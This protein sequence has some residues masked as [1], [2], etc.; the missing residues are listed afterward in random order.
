MYH[1]QHTR[2][3]MLSGSTAP[4]YSVESGDMLRSLHNVLE[5]LNLALLDVS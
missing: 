1:S 4:G 3:R 5:E 2:A